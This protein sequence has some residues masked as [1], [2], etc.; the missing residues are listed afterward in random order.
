MSNLKAAASLAQRI[1]DSTETERL[2]IFEGLRQK[3]KLCETIHHLNTLL[4]SD[5]HHDVGQQ[6]LRALWMIVEPTDT[7]RRD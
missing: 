4:A 7:G 5:Q 2:T 6:A 1:I 3:R